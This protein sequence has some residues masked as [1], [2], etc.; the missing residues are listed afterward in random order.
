MGL[1]DTLVGGTDDLACGHVLLHA[2][3]APA[4]SAGDGEEGGIHFGGDAQHTVDQTRVEIHVGAHLLVDALEGAE[5]LGSQALDGLQEVEVV[6]VALLV[7]LLAGE[8]LFVG[9]TAYRSRL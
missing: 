6:P 5:D 1:G 3:S 7:G 4:G 8:L 2:V 9:Y